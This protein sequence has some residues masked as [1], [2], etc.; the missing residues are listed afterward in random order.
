[1]ALTAFGP[2]SPAGAQS[3]DS[4]LD[5]LVDKGVL[6]VKEADQL[7]DESDKDFDKAYAAKSGMADWVT[8]LKFNGDLRGRYE[9]FHY[10]NAAGVDRYRFRYRLRYGVTAAM[11][12]NLEAGFRLG[13]GDLDSAGQITSGSDPI[14]NNQSFQNNGSKKGI[15]LDLV[16][17]KWSPVRT[18]D[19]QGSVTFG[20]MNNPFVFSDMVFDGDYT[21]EGGA[22]QITRNLVE[23]HS[24]N[25]NGA[26][27][28]LDEIG[29]QS[30]D[31]YLA[32]A[33][34]RLES[35]WTPKFST[36]LGASIL[37]VENEEYLRTADVP[38]I[39]VGN[40]RA[41]TGANTNTLVYDYRPLIGDA[42][43]TY[44]LDE[45]WHYAAP[46]P[47]R[48]GGEYIYNPGAP[49]DNIGWTAGIYL[50]KSGKRGLWELSYRYKYLGADAWYEK[51]VDSDFG[52]F[53]ETQPTGGV[54]GY[55]P[56]TNVKGHIVR[57]GYSP[58]NPLT[59]MLTAFFTELVN[60]TPTA[61]E[62]A[63]TRIQFDAILKF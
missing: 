45:F 38:N 25:F 34:V 17:G 11:T 40:T 5:K 8:A 2:V 3:V 28:V 39:N 50:G 21:P 41:T 46:F 4:L 24:L 19:W 14:S 58:Y 42:S 59:I 18:E 44:H 60:E 27:F 37:G 7:R 20:K 22:L 51:L 6:S 23:G 47:I 63:A 52:A 33:Q 12:D 31:P 15:F 35:T 54:T 29:A 32:G 56:G 48:V 55:G 1:M 62:S 13:S 36:S 10:D 43:M 30:E 61:S 49:T 16:Y 26:G 57:A 9:S 53:Y